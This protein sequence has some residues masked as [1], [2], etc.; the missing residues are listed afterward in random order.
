MV[1]IKLKIKKTNIFPMLLAIYIIRPYY[2]QTN[3]VLN[4]IWAYTTAVLAVWSIGKVTFVIKKRKALFVLLMILYTYCILYVFATITNEI[5]NTFGAISECAQIIGGFNLG[6]LVLLQK[7]KESA[8][9]M[10]CKVFTF[11]LYLDVILGFLNIGTLLGFHKVMTLLGYDN[12]AAYC[13][14]PM[15]VIKFAF[16]Y[17]KNGK[18]KGED[19]FC[20]MLCLLY[21]VRTMSLNG[22]VFL[23]LFGLV[24]FAVTHGVEL[25]RIFTPKNAVIVSAVLILGVSIFNIHALFSEVL[26]SFGKG[27][28]LGGRKIIWDYTIPALFSAPLWGYGH[29]NNGSF[30]TIVGLNPVW[31][32]EANHAHNLLMELWFVNG[33]IGLILYISIIYVCAHGL[34]RKCCNVTYRLLAFGV[35]IYLLM[36]FIDGYPNMPVSYTLFSLLFCVGYKKRY[37]KMCMNVQIT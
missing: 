35:T 6:L 17:Q 15:L 10:V 37:E 24:C 27:T 36:G 5:S 19:W 20:W 25:K 33:I 8:V 22:L 16:D 23:L 21:K 14:V 30:Q 11:Y 3:P 4:A 26:V 12:Y 29:L 28:T 18:I 2:I 31:D 1:K 34:K 7:Q 13:I 32:V 9:F